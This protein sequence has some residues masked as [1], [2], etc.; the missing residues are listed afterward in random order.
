MRPSIWDQEREKAACIADLIGT[1]LTNGA[2]GRLTAEYAARDLVREFIELTESIV[3]PWIRGKIEASEQHQVARFAA[4]FAAE[5][6]SFIPMTPKIRPAVM[7]AAAVA[8]AKLGERVTCF[9]PRAYL[10]GTLWTSRVKK[11][12]G[13][14]TDGKVL[15]REYPWECKALFPNNES[16][17]VLFFMME[18]PLEW[19][20]TVTKYCKDNGH[21]VPLFFGLCNYG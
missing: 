8:M 20:I 6:D 3:P 12:M 2:L 11:S 1:Q 13:D 10:V 4:C 21:P 17:R 16:P 19:V 14:Q 9:V 15:L 7:L 5:T 18:A